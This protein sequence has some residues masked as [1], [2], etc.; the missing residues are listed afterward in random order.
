VRKLPETWL[1]LDLSGETVA[2]TLHDRDRAPRPFSG[3]LDLV[4]A[5]EEIRG[6]PAHDTPRASTTAPLGR[7]D[8]AD[9]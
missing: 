6:R 7:S 8:Q 5:I 1:E 9:S 2:G 3:W 4:A